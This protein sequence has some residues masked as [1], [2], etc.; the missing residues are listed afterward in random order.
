MGRFPSPLQCFLS[1]RASFSSLYRLCAF[2]YVPL[3]T[4][5]I[6]FRKDVPDP[7]FYIHCLSI[8]KSDRN[9]RTVN[10]NF[11]DQ[12]FIFLVFRHA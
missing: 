5:F 8:T 3:E 6:A 11:K 9:C 1:G 12:V 2:L 4:L 10:V 7:G